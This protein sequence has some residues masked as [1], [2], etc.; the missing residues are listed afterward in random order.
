MQRL[1]IEFPQAQCLHRYALA[2]RISDINYGRH[3]GHDAIVGLLHEARAQAFEALG[4]HE[5]DVAGHP[6]VVAELAIQ[7][8]SES[9][10]G[11]AL[12]AETAIPP[13]EGKALTVYQR[14]VRPADERTVAVARIGLVLLDPEQGRPVDVPASF[15]DALAA[16]QRVGAR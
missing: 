12:T 9:R 3:L 8:R 4:H 14:L 15:N 13:V 2:V 11:D 5:W 16:A 1:D 6:S 10:W 7:Y